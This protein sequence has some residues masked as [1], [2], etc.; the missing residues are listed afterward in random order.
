MASRLITLFLFSISSAFQSR[1]PKS[2][3][4]IPQI[5]LACKATRDP[6][7]YESS[8]L[9]SNQVSANSTPSQMIQAVVWV[10]SENLK[11]AHGRVRSILDL[12]ADNRNRS[13]AAKNCLKLLRYSRRRTQSAY[14]AL[15]RGKIKDSVTERAGFWEKDE[16]GAVQPLFKGG[17]PL[18][19]K[20]DVT[21]CKNGS[22]NYTKVQD[23]FNA[24]LDSVAT[25][26]FVIN[27]KAGVYEEIVRVAFKKKNVVFLGD[28]MGK[29]IISVS[30]NTGYMGITT[31]RT[32]TVGSKSVKEY[33]QAMEVAMIRANI[34]E[35]HEATMTRF[36]HGLNSNIANLVELH[37]YVDMEDM[38]HMAIKIERQL[39]SKGSKSN[40]VVSSTS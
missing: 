2:L 24:A 16:A 21:V 19:L 1:H 26:G 13:E 35:D 37:Y 10:S 4:E 29:T 8:L 6:V 14:D 9:Q 3:Q 28:G 31:F 17:F 20:A 40:L 30:L 15:A 33:Y 7:T 18:K 5:P 23:A 34:E 22:C 27:I 25:R 12:S 36:L 11:V 32:A 39:N 38:L